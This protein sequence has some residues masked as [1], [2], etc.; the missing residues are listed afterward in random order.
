[1]QTAQTQLPPLALKI[2]DACRSIGIGR[3]SIYKL[4]AD[5]KLRPVKLAGR[6]LIPRAE[7][8]RLLA[9]SQVA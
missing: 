4:I 3:T 2:D 1:M 8:E 5:G 6:T 9:E 7:L